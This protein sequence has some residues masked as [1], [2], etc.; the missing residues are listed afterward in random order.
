M[1]L[2]RSAALAALLVLSA[3]PA[4][5]AH[6]GVIHTGCPTGQRFTSGAIAVTG[7][8]LR[9]TPKGA[10]SAG[11]YLSVANTGT[12]SDTLLGATSEAASD[13]SLHSMTMDGDMMKM[14][15]VEGGL[16][17]PA[18][19]SVAL[20]PM[21]YHLMMVGMEQPFVEGQ[22]VEMTLHFA[23]AGD[24]KIQ[25][26][27][28]SLTQDGPPTGEGVTPDASMPMDHDMSGMDMG[29]SSMAM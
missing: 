2:L 19:G 11:A 28:G 20:A 7:A 1:A 10:K 27:I 25:L 14:A 17:V 4:A 9:A 23:T 16:E 18:G 15:P 26:N 22:C 12:A 6:K 24:L 21:G 13:I 3:A 5:F 29:S 8:W